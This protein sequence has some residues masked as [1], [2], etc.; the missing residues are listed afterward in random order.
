M[1]NEFLPDTSDSSIHHS[2]PQGCS[3]VGEKALFWML[4]IRKQL[5]KLSKKLIK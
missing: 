1:K 2:C 3:Q 5:I 4:L